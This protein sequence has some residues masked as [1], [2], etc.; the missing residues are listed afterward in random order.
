MTRL[1]AILPFVLLSFAPGAEVQAQADLSDVEMAHVA[2]T[3]NHSDIAY[4][5]L[6]LALSEDPAVREFAEVMIRDHSAVN[7]A[8][9]RLAAKLN[10]EAKDNAVSRQLRADAQRIK[11]E[12]SRLR[13]AEF[14][15]RYAENELRYHQAVNELVESTFIPNIENAEVK[16]AFQQALAIFRGHERHAER[17]VSS[18]VASR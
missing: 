12:L 7:E 8:V 14:D 9:A 4:A 3:A 10:V 13:G 18:V 17:M 15:R 16:Q 2:V 11:D 5:H 1:K 6:A